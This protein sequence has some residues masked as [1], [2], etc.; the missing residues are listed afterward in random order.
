MNRDSEHQGDLQKA[1]A[2]TNT[3]GDIISATFLCII[4]AVKISVQKCTSNFIV[5]VK[6]EMMKLLSSIL[7]SWDRI[8]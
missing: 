1:E 2:A 6:T 7:I 3:W 5:L 8:I 4:C